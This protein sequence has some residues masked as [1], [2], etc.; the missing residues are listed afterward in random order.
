MDG[1]VFLKVLAGETHR[2]EWAY[3]DLVAGALCSTGNRSQAV[4]NLKVPNTRKL[5][6][7]RGHATAPFAPEKTL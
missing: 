6:G 5:S 2:I 3:R 1:R 4:L 7:V